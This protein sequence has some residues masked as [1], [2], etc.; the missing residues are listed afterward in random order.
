MRLCLFEDRWVGQFE[1][2]ALTR[3]VFGLHCGLATLVDKL[4]RHFA[5]Q[6]MGALIRPHLVETARQDYPFLAINEPDWLQS[7]TTVLANGRWLPPVEPASLNLVPHVGLVGDKL[8]YA[9][10]PP[11]LLT[12][13][14]PNTLDDC[15]ETWLQTL[16]SVQA[17]GVIVDHAWQ[18]LHYL[19]DEM[20]KDLAWRTLPVE[21]GFH[22]AHLTLVGP[23]EEL[24]VHETAEIEPW[25]V[26][27]TSR[28]PVVVDREAR[29]EALS[30]LEGPCYIGPRSH[31]MGAKLR[32]SILGPHCRVGG[33][34]EYSILQGFVVKEHEGFLGHS[35]LGAW[36]H[37]SAGVEV[38]SRRL[39]YQP[40]HVSMRGER[41]ETGC[42]RLGVCL[43]DHSQV[44]AGGVL[45]AG[46]LI[47]AFCDLMPQNDLYPR[48]VPS[49]CRV[50]RGR[51]E[52]Q[53]DMLGR[54][55][56]AAELMALRGWSL[57]PIQ[58]A[59]YRGVFDLTAIERRRL[60]SAW[61][62]PSFRAAA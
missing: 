49:F 4:R 44:G 30:R 28:G 1:P 25:V 8:A 50:N 23:S 31:V 24:Y 26:A 38:A 43:G 13:C 22:P 53:E 39:D 45:N 6:E 52:P 62:A 29:V 12:Y 27:D 41:L 59:L 37:L 40:I 54:F 21:R 51:I 9:V 36:T 55:Q 14:S 7:D 61:G 42:R 56:T 11:H 46:S 19:G 17:G 60:S 3:P 15:L 16:S 48:A 57:T 33:E 32:H 20:E 47:G 18:L 10:L 58:E 5:A 35:Y 2:V 34:V